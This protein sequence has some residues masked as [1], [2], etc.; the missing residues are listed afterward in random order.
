[1]I[2]NHRDEPKFTVKHKS[3]PYE[4]MCKQFNTPTDLHHSKYKTRRTFKNMYNYEPRNSNN[5][6]KSIELNSKYGML[7]ADRNRFNNDSHK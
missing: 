5:V 1:M 7:S 3:N 2:M 4:A 6:N